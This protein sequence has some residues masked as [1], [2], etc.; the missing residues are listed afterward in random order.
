MDETR[1]LK[2]AGVTWDLPLSV[3]DGWIKKPYAIQTP[4]TFDLITIEFRK[5]NQA[6]KAKGECCIHACFSA[7]KVMF[8]FLIQSA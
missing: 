3:P 8:S 5:T 2:L 4:R 7:L 1:T 6:N